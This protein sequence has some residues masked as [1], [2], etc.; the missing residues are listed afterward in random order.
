MLKILFKDI[1]VDAF[2]RELIK[3]LKIGRRGGFWQN[4]IF[5]LGDPS[6]DKHYLT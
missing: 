6:V 5:E 1:L 2:L 3:A 4:R